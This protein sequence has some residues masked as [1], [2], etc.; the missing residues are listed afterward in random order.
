MEET[1]NAA[2]LVSAAILGKEVRMVM[3]AGESYD[4]TPPTIHKLAG[5]AYYLADLSEKDATVAQVLYDKEKLENIAKALSFLL[6]GSE[7]LW[8]KLSHGT[9]EEI[10]SAIQ[11]AYSMIGVQDFSTLLALSRNVG[12]LTAQQRP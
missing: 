8:E 11:E 4:I 6:C 7:C 9:V 1:I 12:R 2:R 3:V 10:A 5:A